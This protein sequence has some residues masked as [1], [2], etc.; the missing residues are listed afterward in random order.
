[1]TSQN[2]KIS[3]KYDLIDENYKLDAENF[4]TLNGLRLIFNEIEAK[5]FLNNE[6]DNSVFNIYQYDGTTGNLK[7]HN[8]KEDT[9]VYNRNAAASR[10]IESLRE[11]DIY[12]LKKTD[13][14]KII[15][16]INK[17]QINVKPSNELITLFKSINNISTHLYDENDQDKIIKYSLQ[18]K[19]LLDFFLELK[20]ELGENIQTAKLFFSMIS[21]KEPIDESNESFF[22]KY[23]DI[24][25]PILKN[26]LEKVKK[27]TSKL[28]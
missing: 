12:T 19:L 27:K 1:M 6:A 23:F 18:I 26:Y 24:L 20:T 16:K 25:Y 7:E 22:K 2:S 14:D 17:I 11:S 5:A 13:S 10:T 9:K 15:S 3:P 8:K 4:V 28:F 21:L